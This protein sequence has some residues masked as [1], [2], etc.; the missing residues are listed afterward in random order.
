[1]ISECVFEGERGICLALDELRSHLVLRTST[2]CRARD[3]PLKGFA[4]S[5]GSLSSNFA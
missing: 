5:G 2:D 3:L 4:F 1:M